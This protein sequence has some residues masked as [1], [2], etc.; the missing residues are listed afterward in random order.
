VISPDTNDF[1]WVLERP[2]PECGFDA[3]AHP[4]HQMPT[5][6]RQNAATW[7]ELEAQG[8]IRAGR[9]DPLSWS[10]LEYACHVRDALG[11]LEGRVTMMLAEDDPE[12]AY[13]DQD[14]TAEEEHYDR[15]DPAVVVAELAVAAH[16]LAGL[17]AGLSEA[18]GRRA[19]RR[20]DGAPFTV[21]SISIY[22]LHEAV[23]HLSDVAGPHR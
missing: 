10:S 14:A 8:R 19:G 2:C 23:H 3:R 4:V 15:Q 1:T 11:C 18:D 21:A 16:A 20:S 7:A 6:L 22:A 13:W 17:V 12:F 9:P 5:L